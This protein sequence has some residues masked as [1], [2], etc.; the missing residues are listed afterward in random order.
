MALLSAERAAG[1]AENQPIDGFFAPQRAA[2]WAVMS[3]ADRARIQSAGVAAPG[4]GA[5]AAESSLLCGHCHG[6]RVIE[7]RFWW[8]S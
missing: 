3:S 7:P 5:T 2:P 6:D 1:H 8:S 4:A